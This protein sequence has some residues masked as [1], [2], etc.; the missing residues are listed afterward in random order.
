MPGNFQKHV[1]ALAATKTGDGLVDPKIVLAWMLTALGAP[2][3]LLGWLVPLRE[4][5]SLLPQLF[6]SGWLSSQT[7]RKWAW[8]AGSLAQGACVAGM[9]AAA[10]T[11]EGERAGWTIVGLLAVF[12]CARSVCS[13]TYKDVL[14]RTVP[15]ASRGS[16][17]GAAAS[18]AAGMTLLYGVLLSFGFLE[19]SVSTVA[20][21]LLVA[22][23][24]WVASAGAF[25]M[26]DEPAGKPPESESLFAAVVSQFQLFKTDPQLWRFI[27]VRGLL[28]ATA[29]APP[30]LLALTG[31]QGGRELGALGPFVIASALASVLSG[32]VW[33]RLSDR[34]SRL[35]LAASA[36][37]ACLTLLAASALAV[38]L[39]A[40]F[41]AELVPP[42]LLFV[43]MVAYQGVR[44]GRAT[45][46]VDMAENDSRAAYTA[47]SNTLIGV[48]LMFG[49]LFGLVAEAGGNALT[50]AIFAAMCAVAAVGALT[51]DE[52]QQTSRAHRP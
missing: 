24:L 11:L 42:G 28:T 37:L 39:P 6:I 1:V 43:L 50:L 2:A 18:I 10:W 21:G 41:A 19:R 25:A 32:Y 23:G 40:M 31:R 44:L 26:L 8:A 16:A 29:L 15:K 46:L 38:F 35:V 5:G 17:T 51:L 9:A 34:S 49:G 7:H 30:Y 22:A 4:A 36:A 12:A 3:A 20:G 48:L 33:G 13:V 52:V 45:H 27:A 14:G 47:L